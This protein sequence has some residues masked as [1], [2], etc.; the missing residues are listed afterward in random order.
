MANILKLKTLGG[1][2]GEKPLPESLVS[3]FTNTYVLMSF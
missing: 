3:W 2:T 1:Q